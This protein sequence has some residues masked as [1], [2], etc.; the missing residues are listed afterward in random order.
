MHERNIFKNDK[1]NFEQL[2]QEYPEFTPY[3][4][5]GSSGKPY[6]NFKDPAALRALSVVLLKK[7]FDLNLEI[8]LDRLI[9]TIPLRLNYLHWIEDLLNLNETEECGDEFLG[10][11]VGCGASCI[12]GLL[13]NKMNQWKFIATDVDETSCKYA[14]QNVEQNHMQHQITIQ[15]KRENESFFES[16][17]SQHPQSQTKLF[18]FT[19]CNPPFFAEVYDGHVTYNRTNRRPSPA[20]TSTATESE[21]ATEGG[22]VSFVERMIDESLRTKNAIRWYT[23][24]LGKKSSMKPLIQRLK[25]AEITNYTTTEFSQGRTTRWGLA[26]SFSDNRP[27]SKL[28]EKPSKKKKKAKPFIMSFTRDFFVETEILNIKSTAK[29]TEIDAVVWDIVKVVEKEL[30][31]LQISLDAPEHIELMNSGA[32]ELTGKA[33]AN[34]WIHS[35]QKRRKEKRLELVQDGTTICETQDGTNSCETQDGT[36]SCEIKPNNQDG[37]SISSLNQASA[38]F[39][40]NSNHPNQDGTQSYGKR[41]LDSIS[42]ENESE[43]RNP[44]KL[45]MDDEDSVNKYTNK[46]HETNTNEL[47][48]EKISTELT[49]LETNIVECPLF[50]FSCTA[51]TAKQ[52]H[53]TGGRIPALSMLCLEG[54]RE[55]FHQL[56]LH[57]K[58]KLHGVQISPL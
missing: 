1:P 46:E 34:T 51:S 31:D 35:R 44:K 12:Y 38:S 56:F 28:L 11:D 19:M 57:L 3:L 49:M 54:D 42:F 17:L 25:D 10:I 32:Y 47:K 39:A 4:H 18:H 15:H 48:M 26:W 5:K 8:P 16:V 50:T 30:L 20:S 27:P 45:K 41:T 21:R 23:T 55:Q 29:S 7:Y 40:N 36:T 6:V 58:N 43:I 2:A 37:N 13:G 22:E 24:M 33:F 52:L 9:P 14:Q 53:A